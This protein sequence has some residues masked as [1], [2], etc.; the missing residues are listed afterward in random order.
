MSCIAMDAVLS[1][2]RISNIAGGCQITPFVQFAAVRP[3]APGAPAG[4]PA[5]TPTNWTTNGEKIVTVANYAMAG[6][7]L[8]G[9]GGCSA[10]ACGP[11]RMVWSRSFGFASQVRPP[12]GVAREGSRI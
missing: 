12:L 8:G 2:V 6:V 4:I 9:G 7:E 1:S 5:V 11:R 10:S 3:D